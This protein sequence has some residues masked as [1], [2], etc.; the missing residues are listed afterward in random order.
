MSYLFTYTEVEKTK[1]G[2]SWITCEQKEIFETKRFYDEMEALEYLDDIIEDNGLE[3]EL[4][5]LTDMGR[6]ESPVQLIVFDFNPMVEALENWYE[7]H[8]ITD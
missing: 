8:E 1:S 6:K 7:L 4:I 3:A 5:E 2:A